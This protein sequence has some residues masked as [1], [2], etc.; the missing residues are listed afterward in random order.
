MNPVLAELDRAP[1]TLLLLAALVRPAVVSAL[2]Y[3]AP[4]WSLSLLDLV[5]TSLSPGR[6]GCGPPC[7][8]VVSAGGM[9]ISEFHGRWPA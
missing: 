2:G 4:D 5:P 8:S 6:W 3:V 1:R 7:C 9:A